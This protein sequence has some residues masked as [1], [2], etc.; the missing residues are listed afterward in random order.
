MIELLLQ[1][2]RALSMGLVDQAERLYRQAANADPRNS[3]AVVGL[4]RVSL[5]RGDDAQAWR[6]AKRALRIDP[7]NAAAQRMVERFEEVWRYRGTPLPDP[8][9]DPEPAPSPAP[10]AS[11]APAHVIAMPAAPAAGPMPVGLEPVE[12][13]SPDGSGAEPSAADVPLPGAIGPDPT[14]EAAPVI[15]PAHP[16]PDLEAAAAEADEADGS[17]A[18]PTPE[19]ASQAWARIAAEAGAPVADWPAVDLAPAS[20]DAAATR[21]G[22]PAPAPA[23]DDGDGEA[24]AT[25]PPVEGPASTPPLAETGDAPAGEW[26]PADQEPPS[27][28]T[29]PGLGRVRS[30]FVRKRE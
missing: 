6:E 27:I 9:P 10:P 15:P 4:A 8:E 25:A 12:S 13:R 30:L 5:E 2:E 16:A 28:A 17:G 1:A 11:A 26:P 29:F 14:L 22:A 19:D 21:T 18:E 3:I 20:P 23:A 7:E 24:G